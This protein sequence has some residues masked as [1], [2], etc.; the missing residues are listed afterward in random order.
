[1]ADIDAHKVE[2]RAKIALLY[3]D[4]MHRCS[5]LRSIPD[6]VRK[7]IKI[8]RDYLQKFSQTDPRAHYKIAENLWKQYL[9]SSGKGNPYDII[10]F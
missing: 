1:M 9:W 4:V 6:Y 2:V 8:Y 3:A 5:A 10:D 7:T